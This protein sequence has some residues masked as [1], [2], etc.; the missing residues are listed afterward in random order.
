MPTWR[1]GIYDKDAAAEITLW[2]KHNRLFYCKKQ[3]QKGSEIIVDAENVIISTSYH[4]SIEE[5][6]DIVR[7]K[8]NW[9]RTKQLEYKSASPEIVKPVSEEGSTLPYL[10]VNYPFRIV[11]S[12]EESNRNENIKLVNGEFLI[13]SKSRFI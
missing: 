10:G 7:D 6:N 8:A 13:F 9:I 4:K 12:R 2:Y 11:N 1:G 3:T 5:I